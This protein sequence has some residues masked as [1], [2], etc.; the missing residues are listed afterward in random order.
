MVNAYSTEEIKALRLH[1]ETE[2]LQCRPGA[3]QKRRCCP[4]GQQ[5]LFHLVTVFLRSFRAIRA[6]VL[7]GSKALSR[8]WSISLAAASSLTVGSSL[9]VTSVSG[10]STLR[11]VTEAVPGDFAPHRGALS[12][13]S[14]KIL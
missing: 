5:R 3:D 2:E 4:F 13:L 9:T 7:R 11:S 6:R 14:R 10:A 12:L 1:Q 8:H